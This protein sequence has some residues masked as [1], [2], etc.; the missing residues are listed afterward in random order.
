MAGRWR[1]WRGLSGTCQTKEQRDPPTRLQGVAQM[2]QGDADRASILQHSIPAGKS[3]V[4]VTGV[5]MTAD[6]RARKV[7]DFMYATPE[8]RRM[9][10]VSLKCMPVGNC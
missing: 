2:R 10:S 3:I 6:L 4:M 1:G 7:L 9:Q 5:Y 8:V